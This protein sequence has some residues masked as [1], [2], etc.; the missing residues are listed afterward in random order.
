LP[1]IA[2]GALALQVPLAWAGGEVLE[3]DGLALALAASTLL[4][5]AAL[6]VELHA[7]GATVRRLGAA[8]AFVAGLAVLSF[9]PPALVLGSAAAAAAGVV[10]YVVLLALIRPRS[11][12]ESWHYLRALS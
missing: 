10:L 5:L 2:L 8:A 12:R 9:L 11:L 3:L 6:L 4:V 1:W 7:L